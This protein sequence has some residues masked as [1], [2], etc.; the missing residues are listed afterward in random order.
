MARQVYLAMKL[1][2][3]LAEDLSTLIRRGAMKPGD[4][5]RAVKVLG[6][7]VRSES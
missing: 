5:G 4:R 6:A 1:Y 2:Q 7:S 3:Q